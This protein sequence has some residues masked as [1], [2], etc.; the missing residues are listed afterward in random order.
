MA[1]ADRGYRL[2]VIDDDET[3]RRFYGKLLSGQ[4][5][6]VSEIRQAADGAA[7][8]AALR[9]QVPDC[10]LLDFSLPDQT[11]LEFLDQRHRRRRAALRRRDDHRHRQ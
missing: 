6:G 7:G 9:A 10:L 2:L 11:G 3:D 1:N 8:L 5:Y 4:P